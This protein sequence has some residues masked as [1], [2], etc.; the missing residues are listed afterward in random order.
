MN[1]LS[2][3]DQIKINEFRRALE[4]MEEPTKQ[5]Q[6]ILDEINWIENSDQLDPSIRESH[7]NRRLLLHANRPFDVPTPGISNPVLP[8]PEGYVV[9]DTGGPGFQETVKDKARG[10]G[11]ATAGLVDQARA[12]IGALKETAAGMPKRVRDWA[13]SGP[14]STQSVE[15]NLAAIPGQLKQPEVTGSKLVD[16][17]RARTGDPTATTADA[18]ASVGQDAIGAL[19]RGGQAVA[20]FVSPSAESASGTSDQERELKRK[21]ADRLSKTGL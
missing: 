12:G 7:L 11:Q 15:S 5:Q 9:N 14:I 10:I 4:T 13:N 18:F 2:Q 8:G 21:A 6:Q 3:E 19:K 1:K 16:S 20:D 17:T